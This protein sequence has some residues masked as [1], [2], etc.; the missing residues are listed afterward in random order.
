MASEHVV[1]VTGAAGGIGSEV[2]RILLEDL[3]ACVVATDIVIGE[4]LEQLGKQYQERLEV[5]S[6]DITDASSPA[7]PNLLPWTNQCSLTGCNVR[8]KCGCCRETLWKVDWR[9]SQRGRY[10]TLLSSG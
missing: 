4:K 2:V 3:A 9:L 7:S 10:G 5:V 8:D 1:L 6:G